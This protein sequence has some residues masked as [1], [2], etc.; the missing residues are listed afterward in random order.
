[1]SFAKIDHARRELEIEY[2]WERDRGMHEIRDR[3]NGEREIV[4]R[5][6][7]GREAPASISARA[8]TV[9][10]WSGDRPFTEWVRDASPSLRATLERPGA[11]WRDVH[12]ALADFNLELRAKGSGFVVVDRDNPMLVA[13]AS[14]IGRF[15]SRERLEIC[16]DTFES[17]SETARQSPREIDGE[18]LP[19]EGR[20]R[21]E[22]RQGAAREARIG[23]PARG[24]SHSYRCDPKRRADQRGAAQSPRAIVREVSA[25][26]SPHRSRPICGGVGAPARG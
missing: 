11:A 20:D 15:A 17:A 3:Q 2:G 25:V 16:L 24:E 14:H 5:A 22:Q 26:A 19:R 18:S 1:M 13:K 10:V 9:R 6:L 8:Q 21:S 7:A 23:G 4:R 12:D